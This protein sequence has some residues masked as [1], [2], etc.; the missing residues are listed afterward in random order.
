MVG[1]RSSGSKSI[2]FIRKIQTKAVSASGATELARGF[3]VDDAL[4][5]GVDHLDQEL[6]RG[7]EAAGDAGGDALG[8]APEDEAAEHAQQDGPEQRIELEHRLVNEKSAMPSCTR[9]WK[10]CR[11][12]WMYSPAVGACPSAAIVC[13]SRV[14]AS[15]LVVLRPP[16]HSRAS[17][18]TFMHTTIATSRAGQLRSGTTFAAATSM[19]TASAIF[20]NSHSMNPNTKAPG[21]PCW[22]VW[23]C[24]APTRRPAPPRRPRRTART[25]PPH[26]CR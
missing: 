23:S 6:D 7:L 15:R 24:R 8:N 4:G 3:V 20:T 11:W 19:A 12:C 22:F 16:R 25:R 1:M 9:F 10:C 21:S 2:A 18:F 17:Q 26:P 13:S 14:V 5:L